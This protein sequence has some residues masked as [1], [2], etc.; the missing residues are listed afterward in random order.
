MHSFSFDVVLDHEGNRYLVN[1]K[2]VRDKWDRTPGRALKNRIN[3]LRESVSDPHE[4]EAMKRKDR[5]AAEF[6]A[7]IE[8][9]KKLTRDQTEQILK[10]PKTALRYVMEAMDGPWR[11]FEK[12]VRAADLTASQAVD[13]A[14]KIRRRRWRNFENKIKRSVAPLGEYRRAFSGSIAFCDAEIFKLQL[15]EWRRR[16]KRAHC[17]PARRS[18]Q[19]WAEAM[20]RDDRYEGRL[21]DRPYSFDRY[22]RLL[23]S[24]ATSLMAHRYR[25]KLESYFD[26]TETEEKQVESLNRIARKLCRR[27]DRPVPFWETSIATDP[28]C[29]FNDAKAIG[30]RFVRGEKAIMADPD[31]ARRYRRH[32]LRPSCD[33]QS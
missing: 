15:E 19:G 32:F 7:A 33:P 13:Y 18:V 10:E 29:S 28:A 30:A 11:Q 8:G 4:M 31:L 9:K 27:F 17:R 3:E 14:V 26:F 20:I 21:I 22:C 1:R 25:S 16:E 5:V 24:N 12:Q 2:V 23:A 6:K